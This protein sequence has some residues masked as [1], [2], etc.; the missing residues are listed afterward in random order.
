MSRSGVRYAG[1]ACLIS[2]LVGAVAELVL[3]LWT[4]QVPDD[5][6]SY[7]LSSSQF[8]VAQVFFFLTHAALLAGVVAFAATQTQTAARRGALLAA[9]GMAGWTITELLA[10]P[11]ADHEAE[12]V[13]TGLVGTSFGVSCTLIGIGMLVAGIA[14]LRGPRANGWRDGVPLAIG[15]SE[16]AILTP[17]IVSGVPWIQHLAV[18]IWMLLFAGLG[19]SLFVATGA[20]AS[21]RASSLNWAQ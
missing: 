16:F 8:T 20:A 2:G 10:I 19:W 5:V 14:I 6:F 21:R 3:L 9:V 12:A 4:P 7:P 11:Y 17:G 15:I 18:G 13:N 1:L